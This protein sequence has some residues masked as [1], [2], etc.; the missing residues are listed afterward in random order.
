MDVFKGSG[1]RGTEWLNSNH[2]KIDFGET[3]ISRVGTVKLLL[4]ESA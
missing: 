3:Q 4:L 2:L 1:A